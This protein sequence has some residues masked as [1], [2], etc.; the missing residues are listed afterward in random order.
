MT[1]LKTSVLS[2]RDIDCAAEILA[3][4][5]LLAF[6]TET[7]YG[8]GADACNGIAVARIFAAKNRPRFN[9]LIVHVPDLAA[10]R[11]LVVFDE[12]ALRLASAL[13]P[14]PLSLVLP[15]RKGGG[16]S[17]LVTAGLDTLAVRIPGPALARDLLVR[18]GCPVAA[19]SA[20][21]SGRISPTSAR[22]VLDGLS[23]RIDAVLDGGECD[24]GLES[25]IMTSDPPR[26]LRP[27]GVS[28]E[29]VEAVLGRRVETASHPAPPSDG[30]AP[31]ER[32]N[33]P[34]QL[35]SHYAPQA[36]LRL[37]AESPASGEI[38]IGFGV[39]GDLDGGNGEA[40]NLSPEGDV[41]RAA[42]NLFTVLRRADELAQGALCKKI[43]V[44]PIPNDGLGWAI[45][46]RLARAAA[47]RD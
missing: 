40:L 25:T 18:A 22:H 29:A 24:V 9:P 36:E 2:E 46:D 19:P 6:P 23:G 12:T 14:G 27:G 13:W 17:S 11:R 7:V 34:G 32:P 43:A 21:P 41:T 8:L 44:A 20:N 42:A 26:I 30:S 1:V 15:L 31:D 3:R 37:N 47:P 35:Q 5:G 38:Y 39:H 45:N 28:R 10:A 16:I 4:G 33:A